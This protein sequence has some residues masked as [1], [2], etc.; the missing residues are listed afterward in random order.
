MGQLVLRNS[1]SLHYSILCLSNE[2]CSRQILEELIKFGA[3]KAFIA[4]IG[5]GPTLF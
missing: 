3:K 1:F 4:N 5:K 2:S